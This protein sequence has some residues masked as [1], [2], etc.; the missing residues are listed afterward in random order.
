M[1][2]CL[3]I[4]TDEAITNTQQNGA[5]C[6]KIK[7]SAYYLEQKPFIVKSFRVIRKDE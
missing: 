4:A 1:I 7:R 6:F 2:V 3:K 5:S